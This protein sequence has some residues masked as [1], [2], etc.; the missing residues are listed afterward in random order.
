ME[1]IVLPNLVASISDKKTTTVIN[2]FLHSDNP[3]MRIHAAMLISLRMDE[4]YKKYSELLLKELKNPLHFQIVRLGVKSAWIIA[5]GLAENLKEEDYYKLQDSILE[6]EM[7]EREGLKDWLKDFPTQIG[8][9][10]KE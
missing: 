6:W 8:I 10:F 7:E 2:E 9:L 3:M 4:H 1:K 5:V